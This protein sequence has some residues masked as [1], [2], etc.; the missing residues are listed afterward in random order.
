MNE[1]SPSFDL[2]LREIEKIALLTREE[3]R[4]IATRAFRG[5]EEARN[6]LVEHN[7]RFVVSVAKKYQGKGVSLQDLVNSGNESLITAARKFDPSKGVRFISYAVWWI[8][9]SI[10]KILGEQGHPVRVPLN[11]T[12]ERIRINRIQQTALKTI[13]RNLTLIEVAKLCGITEEN[14]RL[15]LED[16]SSVSLDAQKRE[17]DDEPIYSYFPD[18]AQENPHQEWE[19]ADLR[20][21]ILGLIYQHCSPREAKILIMYYGLNGEDSVTLEVIAS[22][23]GVTRERIRQIREKAQARLKM[24]L[25]INFLVDRL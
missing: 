2:Y 18:Q 24:F 14:A 21:Y 17:K 20:K 1:E 25:P 23:M 13:G 10:Y 16:N 3:E 11:K 6:N 4:S 5:D 7:L 15:L 12:N 19:S 9:Q 8:K 22:R